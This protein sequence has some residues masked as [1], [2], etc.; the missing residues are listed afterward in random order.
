MEVVRAYGARISMTRID[1][2]QHFWVLA[3]GDYDWLTPEL[4]RV[5]RDFLPEDLEPLLDRNG[6]DGTVLVQAAATV[7]ETEFMLDLAR[8]HAF[9][10]GVV[11]WVDFESSEAPDEIA[12]LARDARLVGLR[13]MIQDIEDVDW[14]LRPG[15]DPA[16]QALI[17]HDLTLDALTHPRHLPNL[18]ELL[19][20]HGSM[21]V[22][23]DH[24][25]KPCIRDRIVRGWAKDMTVLA[26]QTAAYCKLSGLV[27]EAS[28]DWT[29][30]ELKPYVD[31]LI[32]CFGTD[33]LIW[34]SD[35][36]VCTLAAPYDRWVEA[37]EELLSGLSGDERQQI[38]G[39]NAKRAYRLR[40]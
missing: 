38:M 37:T 31:H 40:E 4:D 18:L 32:D 2:H 5:Y 8:Q 33:R 6:F 29:V 30:A 12:R 19:D 7:D 9:I 34:G 28:T 1:A 24:G 20:R 21:R 23:I 10:R 25:S 16:F 11:G 27:T 35:W 15:L 26:G 17:A 22:V 14:M 3:R 13:P 36:P 39:E